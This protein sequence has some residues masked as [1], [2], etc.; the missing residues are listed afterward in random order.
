VRCIA[1][2]S[3]AWQLG[4][5]EQAVAPGPEAAAVEC[6]VKTPAGCGEKAPEKLP[7]GVS[8]EDV[9]QSIAQAT[10]NGTDCPLRLR[11][12]TPQRLRNEQAWSRSALYAALG[13]R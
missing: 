13:K 11:E 4:R 10:P 3:F 9:W 8:K 2:D 7:D 1:H 5:G 6:P 12:E